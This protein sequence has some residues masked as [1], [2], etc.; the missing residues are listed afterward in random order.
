MR[1]PKKRVRGRVVPPLAET[2]VHVRRAVVAGDPAAIVPMLVGGRDPAKRL[3]IHQRNYETSLVNALLGK[4]P[5]TGWL[6]G[7]GFLTQAA[8]EF[9]RLNPPRAP[10]IAEYGEEFPGYLEMRPHAE[11]A[12][13]MRAFAELE[14]C[15]GHAA[16][17]ADR[18]ALRLHE[19]GGLDAETLCDATLVIQDGVHYLAATWPADELMKTYLAE[20]ASDELQLAPG[21]F[22]FEIRGSRGAFQINRLDAGEFAFRK[23]IR[24]GRTIGGSAELALEADPGFDTGRSFLQLITDGLAVTI[25][26][27]ESRQI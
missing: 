27:N 23:A 21:D 16:I 5:A 13:Y 22:R 10:C 17:A 2:Q 4:F 14:W 18:P 20:Q 1:L 11:R 9:V 19:V 15:L 26:Q 12:P 7:S 24:E 3:A 8:R 25:A 6:V